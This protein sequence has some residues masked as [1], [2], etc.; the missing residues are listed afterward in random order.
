MNRQLTPGLVQRKAGRALT[1]ALRILLLRAGDV[2][3]NPGMPPKEKRVFTPSA[4]C[5]H[6]A[7]H[8]VRPC[9]VASREP[10]APAPPTTRKEEPLPDPASLDTAQ[11]SPPTAQL[12][13]G[14]T[15]QRHQFAS[16]QV[17]PVGDIAA[18]PSPA[19]APQ[20]PPA[21]RDHLDTRCA[22]DTPRPA[23]ACVEQQRP[24]MDCAGPE[25]EELFVSPPVRVRGSEDP[26]V[27]AESPPSEHATPA[28]PPVPAP[29]PPPAE[30]DKVAKTPPQDARSFPALQR[31]T[32]TQDVFCSFLP[33][34]RSCT[35]GARHG[36]KD[37]PQD[38]RSFLALQRCTYTQDFFCSF[39]PV[40]R[41]CTTTEDEEGDFRFSR[42]CGGILRAGGL[43]RRWSQRAPRTR[44]THGP[45]PPWVRPCP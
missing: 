6:K 16:A 30:R 33:V 4:P 21:T 28:T 19:A 15:P 35:T 43:D 32:Y 41:S 18:L 45:V 7:P 20:A 38:A 31:C 25:F 24:V 27:L 39:L 1:D 12:R 34:R 29:C 8:S 42:V 3:R 13:T 40:R 23:H 44:T 10:P 5:G 22:H 17:I 37:S 11:A 9:C 36:L 26:T 14:T 2:E